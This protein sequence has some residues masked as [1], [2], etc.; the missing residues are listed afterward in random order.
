MHTTDPQVRKDTI[1][2]LRLLADQLAADERIPVPCAGFGLYTFARGREEV[3]EVA[4]ALGVPVTT[5]R[6]EGERGAVVRVLAARDFG[7]VRYV[8]EW[9]ALE[10]K[11]VR[12]AGPARRPEC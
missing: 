2:G 6:T 4:R 11:P 8:Y 10:D 5:E 3:L 12:A 9:L 7:G 1:D